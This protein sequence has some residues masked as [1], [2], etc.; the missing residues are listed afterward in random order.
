MSRWQYP[1]IAAMAAFNAPAD[2]AIE[3]A[4]AGY[5]ACNSYNVTTKVSYYSPIVV[6]PY[7]D[8]SWTRRLE[9]D[10]ARYTAKN[11]PGEYHGGGAS[12]WV[13]RNEADTRQEIASS[14]RAHTM[15]DNRKTWRDVT[16]WVAPN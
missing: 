11:F 13:R 10:F 1:L 9:A 8:Q 12:C 2:A 16:E 7:D 6:R 3:S 14:K 4:R 15:Y 5:Y